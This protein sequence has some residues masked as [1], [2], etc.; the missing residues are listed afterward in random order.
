[1]SLNIKNPR[2]HRLAQEVAALTGESLAQ[3][4]TTA[5]EE[6]KARLE[7]DARFERAW[8]IA[9]GMAKRMNAQPDGAKFLEAEDLYDDETGLPK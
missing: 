1:M 5:L 2:A 7:K 6:R 4:V 9:A 8:A 3:A